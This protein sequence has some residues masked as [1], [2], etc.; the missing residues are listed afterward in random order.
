MQERAKL[1]ISISH[2]DHQEALDCAA[3]ERF[4]PH[5]HGVKI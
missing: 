4:G 3:F 2:P 5:Y 1:L